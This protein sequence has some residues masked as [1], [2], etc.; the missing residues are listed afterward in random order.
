MSQ[1]RFQ[2]TG[3][4]WIVHCFDG[5]SGFDDPYFPFKTTQCIVP[6]KTWRHSNFVVLL[7][8]FIRAA[9]A[10]AFFCNDTFDCS[11][12][13]L[14]PNCWVL[15]IFFTTCKGKTAAFDEGSKKGRQDQEPDTLGNLNTSRWTK[16]WLLGGMRYDSW[17]VFYLKRH[18]FWMVLTL[19]PS[20][21]Y[22]WGEKQTILQVSVCYYT[23]TRP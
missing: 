20:D 3:F 17:P 2:T 15:N 19:I 23:N 6:K 9:H 13:H 5:L 11:C 14:Y 16:M 18:G 22:F 21:M 8:N 7:I 12:C 1:K 10:R 4:S